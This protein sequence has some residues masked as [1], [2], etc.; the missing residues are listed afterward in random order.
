MTRRAIRYLV[1]DWNGTLLDDVFACVA[2]LNVL[3][4]R[5]RLPRVRLP[6]YRAVFGF[7]VR[8]YYDTLGFQLSDADWHRIAADY[9]QLYARTAAHAPLRKG[10]HSTLRLLSRRGLPSAILSAS[11]IGILQ[12]MLAARNIHS[13]FQEIAGLSDRLAHSK[14][15]AGQTLLNRLPVQPDEVLL[16]GDTDHDY[17]VAQALR[18]RCILL[19]GGHQALWRLRA[20]ACPV[21]SDIRQLPVWLNRMPAAAS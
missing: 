13:L 11:E 8:R 4:C 7:P 17:E 1:W 15:E 16:I 10:A 2:A 14:L 20:C 6:R 9:H 19:A 5:H 12:R 18:C 3:L 21:L